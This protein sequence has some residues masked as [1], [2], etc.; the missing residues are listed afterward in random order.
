[1]MISLADLSVTIDGQ[2]S[3]SVSL[4]DDKLVWT[5]TLPATPTPV[6]V[7]EAAVGRGVYALQTPPAKILDTFHVEL[8]TVGSDVRML[9]L[10]MQPT[11]TDRKSG[12]TTYTWN[13]KRL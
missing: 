10:S 6:D 12:S 8:T 9:E 3:E 11:Q 7:R 13:Y 4:H 2:P 1:Q 5:G